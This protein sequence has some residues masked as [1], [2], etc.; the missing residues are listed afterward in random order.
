M[1]ATE[2]SAEGKAGLDALIGAPETGLIASDFDGTLSPIVSSPGQARPETGAIEALTRLART[3]GSVA[4]I[5]GRAAA[6]A[7]A[8]GGLDT[9]PGVVVLGHYGAERWEDGS[10]TTAPAP[11]GIA[12]VRARLPAL[13]A[14]AAAG[15]RI[16]DKGTALAVHTRQTAD[17]AATLESLR[18]ALETL[19]A[20]AELALEPGKFVLEL[21]PPGIDKGKA[22]RDLVA[23]RAARSAV[24]CG[25]DLGD[26]AAFAAIR[27]LRGD[28]IPGCTVC[29]SSPEAERVAREA[30]LVADG[31]TGIVAFLEWLAS[32]LHA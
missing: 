13:V 30:D 9:I 29:S 20:Q 14:D 6:E 1:I 28:G 10:L 3:V 26:L 24:Y 4:I 32:S 23:E 8:V 22:L 17:P 19:A 2:L 12:T 31:P 15:T 27:Q 21:R 16:E 25:D 5:T 18:P 11:P 7:V